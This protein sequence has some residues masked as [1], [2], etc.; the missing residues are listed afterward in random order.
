MIVYNFIKYYNR[1][2][3]KNQGIRFF[4]PNIFKILLI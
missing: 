1:Y 2:I 3:Y 4:I